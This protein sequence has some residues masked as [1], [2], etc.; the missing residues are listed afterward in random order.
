RRHAACERFENGKAE[1]FV[2]R[3]EAE[4]VG[5][6]VERVE[7][8]PRLRADHAYE[9]AVDSLDVAP[10][11]GPRDDER[12]VRMRPADAFHRA[13]ERGYVRARRAGPDGQRVRTLDAGPRD[14]AVDLVG[15]AGYRRVDAERDDGDAVAVESARLE[16]ERG[17]RRRDD[18]DVGV[19]AG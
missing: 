11:L 18:H 2:E 4:R 3:S 9:G 12:E 1:A 19:T 8:G 14:C 13:R 6:A 5:A 10:A 7:H 17:E 16:L 15:V